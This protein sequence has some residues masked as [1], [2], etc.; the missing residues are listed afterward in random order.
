MD[1]VKP[2]DGIELERAT[3]PIAEVRTLVGELEA[4]LSAHYP[5]HQ[6]HG[7]KLDSLFEPH[8][9]FYVA[10]LGGV[11]AGCG[12]V[13]FLDGF[14]ELKRMYVREALRGRGV[15]DAVLRRLEA[16]AGE[17]GY[18]VLRLETGD[19]QL[20]AMRFYERAGF[21]RRAAFGAYAAMPPEATQTSV[22][23]EKLLP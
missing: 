22:F 17:A 4:T 20:A 15:A 10:R 6:R 9:R 16:E 23:M 21:R 12:G 5:A 8:I 11:P 18:V 1:Q 14:A 2:A 3:A 19:K 7:L 13:A